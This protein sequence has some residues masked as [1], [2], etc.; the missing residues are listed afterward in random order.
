LCA[1]IRYDRND[2]VPE[3]LIAML[4]DVLDVLEPR[5]RRFGFAIRCAASL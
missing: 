1:S 5:R 2:K 4:A 3:A